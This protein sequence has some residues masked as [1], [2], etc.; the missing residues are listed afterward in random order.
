M[1]KL[2]YIKDLRNIVVKVRISGPITQKTLQ[3]VKFALKSP[4]LSNPVALAV[5]IN[6]SGGSAVQS[7][8][9]RKEIQS[10]SAKH[11]V[12]SYTFAED[13]AVSGAYLVLSAGHEVYSSSAS[14]LGCIGSSVNLFEFKE[15]AEYYGVKRRA[16]TTSKKD[17]VGMLDPLT[18]LTEEAK[19]WVKGT[20]ES[21]KTQLE[22]IINETRAGKVIK[23]KAFTGEYFNTEEAVSLGLVDF[24]GNCDEVIQKLYP[25]TRIVEPKMSQFRKALE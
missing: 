14:L 5:V 8:L 23:D 11:K 22:N 1:D 13:F 4:V 2:K 17:L 19:Q 15:L 18:P 7:N 21:S 24:V 3:D 25:G 20:L 12:K 10:F 6:S 16:W 9:I